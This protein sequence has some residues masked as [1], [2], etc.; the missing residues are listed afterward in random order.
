VVRS[1]SNKVRMVSAGVAW[2]APGHAQLPHQ[3]SV[4]DCLVPPGSV[5]FQCLIS[6]FEP[7][8]P[9]VGTAESCAPRK[10]RTRGLWV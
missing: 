3:A 4:K 10:H 8:T 1:F 2:I 6:G 9:A 5:W 7:A